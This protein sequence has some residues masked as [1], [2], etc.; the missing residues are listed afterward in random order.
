MSCVFSIIVPF[1]NEENRLTHSIKSVINQAFKNWEIIAINDASNDQSL[2]IIQNFAKDDKR[3][4]VINLFQ[5][6]GIG[7]CRNIA[8]KKAKGDYI[9]FLDADDYFS[10][11]ALEKLSIAVEKKP[12]IEVFLWGYC[13]F[14]DKSPT[15]KKFLPQKPNKKLGETPFELGMLNRKGF[16]SVPWIYILKKK[17]I[18]SHKI[19]FSEFTFYEDLKFTNEVLFYVKSVIT[20]PFVGYHYR[21]HKTSVTGKPTKEKIHQKF[22]EF[23]KIRIFLIENKLYAHYK[24]LYV[25]RFLTFCV[26]TS[27]NEYFSLKKTEKDCHIDEKMENIRKSL[28]LKDEKLNLLK[29]I[30]FLIDKHNENELYNFYLASY[31]GLKNIKNRYGLY[32]FMIRLVF[33]FKSI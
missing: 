18:T 1:F 2:E 33:Y 4:N 10:K 11:N 14:N 25:A 21:K 6:R 26:F 3:I 19:S 5:N 22:A 30:T 7:Y 16:T 27:F 13:I 9:L 28:W 15:S 29:T 24:Q 31:I 32:K 8:L 23:E 17:F 12:K 20:L